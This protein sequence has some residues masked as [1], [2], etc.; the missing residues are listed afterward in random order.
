MK[1]RIMKNLI[2]LTLLIIFAGCSGTPGSRNIENKVE[3]SLLQ[4]G[5]DKVWTINRVDHVNGLQKD[6]TTYVAIVEYDLTFKMDLN[7]FTETDIDLGTESAV[8]IFEAV[9]VIGQMAAKFGD[10][11]A[12]DS[13]TLEDEFTFIK[14]DKGW[15]LIE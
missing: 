9:E 15:E 5:F 6:E 4:G 8:G 13:F 10:F 7:E 3:A 11:E 1:F 14:M 2:L 12:G